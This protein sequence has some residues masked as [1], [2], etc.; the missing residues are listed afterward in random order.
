MYGLVIEGVEYYL[1]QQYGNDVLK[2]IM[3]MGSLF[4]WL[5]QVLYSIMVSASS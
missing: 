5:T 1:K 3:K 4:A 2:R